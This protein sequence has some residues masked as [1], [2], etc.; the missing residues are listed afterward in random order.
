MPLFPYNREKFNNKRKKPNLKFPVIILAII[1]IIIIVSKKKYE[2]RFPYLVLDGNVLITIELTNTR[3]NKIKK[4][5]ITALYKDTNVF[6]R[7][8]SKVG[9]YLE[10]RNIFKEKSKVINSRVISNYERF[11][12]YLLEQKNIDSN[13][14]RIVINEKKDITKTIF[15][16]RLGDSWVDNNIGLTSKLVEFDTLR[17]LGKDRECY[18]IIRY[19]NEGNRNLILSIAESS[20]KTQNKEDSISTIR[21]NLNSLW[22]E[23]YTRDI[24]WVKSKYPNGDIETIID[25]EELY[26]FERI[27]RLFGIGVR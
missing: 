27:P 20:I 24:G 19:I 8:D 18:K 11:P 1:L 22:T 23:W 9:L 17:V 5:T 6:L 2:E 25:I 13:N 10:K 21:R 3:K 16:I 26:W 15:P 7:R 14:K 12:F 4:D